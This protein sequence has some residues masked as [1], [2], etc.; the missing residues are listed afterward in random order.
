MMMSFLA[1]FIILVVLLISAS[2][3]LGRQ[4]LIA[5]REFT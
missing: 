2:V 1:L 3:V 4:I 5:A